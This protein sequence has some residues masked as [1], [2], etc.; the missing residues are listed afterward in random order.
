MPHV[1]DAFSLIARRYCELIDGRGAQD[2]DAFLSLASACL[3][4]LAAAA[5]RLPPVEGDDLGAVPDRM[6]D[7]AWAE[8]CRSLTE[9]LGER[10]GYWHVH[11]PA[12][13]SEHEPCRRSLADDLGDIFRDVSRGL[14]AWDLQRLDQAAWEWRF[15]YW[16]HWGAH[17]M[18]ALAAIHALERRTR[19]R[20]ETE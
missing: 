9:Q 19:A 18:G 17:A 15:G 12:S 11:D 1:G 8:L 4:E 6:N 14:V 5:Q 16:S 10:N 3:L 13:A 2:P 7:D 20:D